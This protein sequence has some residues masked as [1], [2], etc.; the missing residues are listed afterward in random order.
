MSCLVTEFAKKT[1]D[2]ASLSATDLQVLALTY[3]LEAEIVG[4]AH[5][6]KEPDKKVL[7]SILKIFIDRFGLHSS[8][9]KVCL[10]GFSPLSFPACQHA[11]MKGKTF[12]CL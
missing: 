1:G 7:C 3:Q 9:R 6:N 2:Y 8:V 12:R 5:L 10:T 11:S 4:V